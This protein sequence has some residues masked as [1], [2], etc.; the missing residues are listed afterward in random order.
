MLS[1]IRQEQHSTKIIRQKPLDSSKIWPDSKFIKKIVI[2]KRHL[3]LQEYWN[4]TRIIFHYTNLTASWVLLIHLAEPQSRPVKMIIFTYAWPLIILPHFKFKQNKQI[5]S[6]FDWL[7]LWLA[8][9][10][11]DETWKF[12]H[13]IHFCSK[14]TLLYALA[15]YF[16]IYRSFIKMHSPWIDV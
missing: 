14:L 7:D 1:Y 5:S 15:D 4:N 6:G 12:Q 8:E 3:N 2:I 10:I 16:A 11:I 9:W 13:C